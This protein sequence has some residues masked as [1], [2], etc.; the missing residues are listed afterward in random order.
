MSQVTN[1]IQPRDVIALTTFDGNIDP[2]NIKPLIFIAQ[3]TH[4]KMFLGLDLYNK[5]YN[6]FVAN[7]LT[8]IYQTIYEDYVVDFLSYY[9]SVLFVD[10]GGYKVSENGLHKITSENMTALD[11]SETDKLSNR[12]NALI[13]GVEFN[14]KEYVSDKQLPE[15]ASKIIVVEDTFPWH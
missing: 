13:A 5:I 7:T 2:D 10:F 6:D 1:M 8:G 9:T 15:L 3:T 4:L 12:Y 11:S 14:F